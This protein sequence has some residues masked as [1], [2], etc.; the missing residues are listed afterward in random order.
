MLSW[1]SLFA[2]LAVFALAQ[3]DTELRA[4][5]APAIFPL[6]LLG[7]AASGSAILAGSIAIV[8]SRRPSGFWPRARALVLAILATLLALVLLTCQPLPAPAQTHALIMATLAG[9]LALAPRLL[10]LSP[11][12]TW[13]ER[14]APVTF[15]ATLVLLTL[16]TLPGEPAAPNDSRPHIDPPIGDR[17]PPADSEAANA[18]N[19]ALQRFRAAVDYDWSGFRGDLARARASVQ[20]LEALQAAFAPLPEAWSGVPK[21]ERAALNKAAGDLMHAVVAATDPDRPKGLPSLASLGAGPDDFADY[22][23]VGA[24]YYG[25]ICGL[26][27]A[28]TPASTSIPR[29]DLEKAAAQ[30][31][32]VLVGNLRRIGS[33]WSDTWAASAIPV[34]MLDG[35]D[36]EPSA[37]ELLMSELFHD[38]RKAYHANEI[39]ALWS[40]DLAQARRLQDND[41]NTCGGRPSIGKGQYR[42]NCYAFSVTP[43]AMASRLAAELR[44]VY[45]TDRGAAPIELW[46]ALPMPD[47]LSGANRQRLQANILEHFLSAVRQADLV[48]IGSGNNAGISPKYASTGALAWQIST[49]EKR[50][51]YLDGRDWVIIRVEEG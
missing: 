39:D 8:G 16:L 26:L 51:Y 41:R 9:S 24:S 32:D 33:R 44:I 34:G 14:V 10:R 4:S 42:I 37:R 1:V 36:P 12:S 49:H 17:P 3:R 18:T 28:L 38:G 43:D 23:I 15:L 11:S 48:I 40:I 45:H 22:A 19:L 31:R 47:G 6:S 21:A 25:A 20:E 50:N 46:Y 27:Q 2:F 5:F 7:W 29:S 13:S 30:G 35:L